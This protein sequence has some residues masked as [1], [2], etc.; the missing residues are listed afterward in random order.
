MIN[1]FMSPFYATKYPLS[2][3]NHVK[4]YIADFRHQCIYTLQHILKNRNFYLVCIQS[5]PLAPLLCCNTCY[6]ELF[7]H[8]KLS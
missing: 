5:Q 6:I 2:S 7:D 1:L 4:C 3:T 8:G